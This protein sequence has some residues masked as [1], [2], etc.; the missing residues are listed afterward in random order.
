MFQLPKFPDPIKLA[1]GK[2]DRYFRSCMVLSFTWRQRW[3]L[4]TG[5]R[6][7]MQQVVVQKGP[8]LAE[9]TKFMV[10]AVTNRWTPAELLKSDNLPEGWRISDSEVYP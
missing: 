6:L 5:G 10:L 2:P 3:M 9:E 7:L 1:G 8:G 4:L